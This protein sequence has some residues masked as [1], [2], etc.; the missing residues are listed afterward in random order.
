MANLDATY[1]TLSKDIDDGNQLCKRSGAGA[2]SLAPMAN[3][4]PCF[5]NILNPRMSFSVA[6]LILAIFLGSFR[7]V[8]FTLIVSTF[9]RLIRDS[10]LGNFRFDWRVDRGLS[11]IEMGSQMNLCSYR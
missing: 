3:G 4:S 5:W 8:S 2:N 6:H 10:S 9:A 7:A 1:S 11:I